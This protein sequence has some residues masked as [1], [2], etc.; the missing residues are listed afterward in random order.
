MRPD[1]SPERGRR[2]VV[3]L[4]RGAEGW[5]CSRGGG[6]DERR[7]FFANGSGEESPRD[8][9]ARA[10][11]VMVTFTL[12]RSGQLSSRKE[13][14]AGRTG[15][16]ARG[17]RGETA[18]GAGCGIRG[19]VAGVRKRLGERGTGTRAGEAKASLGAKRK[20][21]AGRCGGNG[22]FSMSSLQKRSDSKSERGGG[23]RGARSMEPR[24][25]SSSQNGSSAM[26]EE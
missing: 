22:S 4:R 11:G 24:R 19:G 3:C 12:F 20:S 14:Q 13:R 16:S 23:G 2:S 9:L 6:G 25:H 8:R 21:S 10:A 1:C 5:T 26:V 18:R 7:G 15:L 17:L